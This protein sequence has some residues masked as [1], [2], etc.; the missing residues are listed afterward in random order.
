MAI[1]GMM[2]FQTRDILEIG[3]KLL[4]ESFTF[5]FPPVNGFAQLSLGSHN[6]LGDRSWARCSIK[7]LTHRDDSGQDHVIPLEDSPPALIAYDD[8][9][10]SITIEVGVSDCVAIFLVQIFIFG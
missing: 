6:E 3:D 8:R 2:A 4:T 1:K 7:Q 9:M 5:E 10:S